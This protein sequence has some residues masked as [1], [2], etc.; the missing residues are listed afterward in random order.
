MQTGE[1]VDESLAEGHRLGL[2]LAVDEQEIA[3][4]HPHVDAHALCI[5][6]VDVAHHGQRLVVIGIEA[7]VLQ[8]QVAA[9]D[10]HRVVVETHPDA[11]RHTDEI[12][13]VD[14][15]LAVDVWVLRRSLDGQRTVAIA[16]QTDEL[17]GHETIGQRQRHAC[18]RK[19][20]VDVTLVLVGT[21]QQSELFIVEHQACFNSMGVVLLHH[22]D[23][24]SAD[25][26]DRRFLIGHI[27]NGHIGG[28]GEVAF[29]ILNDVIVA[30]KLACD[31]WQ[32]RQYGCHLTE[33]EPVHRD[34]QV[35]QH[36]GVLL[37]CIDLHTSL[38]VGN[39]VDFGLNTVVACQ[40]YEVVLVQ[41]ELLVAD[42]GALWQ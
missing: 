24:L 37:F 32:V 2:L 15:D 39:E 29:L 18:H 42:C 8:Q 22:I 33:V 3:G 1:E 26:A 27:L 30:V 10:A 6:E 7:E 35:L 12:G 38:V 4:A 25:I 13:G 23:K 17:V 28:Y 19:G 41:I 21:A 34:R 5:A 9:H 31:V 36:R 20:R 14:I 11:V 40:E 16:L